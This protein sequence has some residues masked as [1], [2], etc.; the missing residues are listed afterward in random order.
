MVGRFE[1]LRLVPEVMKQVNSRSPTQPTG[2][3]AEKT[4]VFHGNA[5]GV[6]V[7]TRRAKLDS[8]APRVFLVSPA[9][10]AGIRAQ[11]LFPPETTSIL[12]QRLIK[13]GVA[14]EELFCF[15]SSLYFRGKLAYARLFANPPRSLPGVLIIAAGLGLQPPETV[16]TASDVQQMSSVQ[17]DLAHPEYR[18]ALERDARTLR[19]NIG[20]DVPVVL[21]GSIATQKYVE[22]LA[23]IFGE[24]LLFPSAFVGRGSMSRGGLLLRCC[25]EKVEL[26]YVP[27]ITTLRRGARP[28]RLLPRRP[29]VNKG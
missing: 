24:Q 27:V 16:V 1:F 11:R 13:N 18:S 22:P 17:V 23:E 29:T 5:P 25:R 21:L 8:G 10:L 3:R 26:D 7:T 9:N 2:V 14:L 6:G 20:S 19:E 28:P 12:G 15:I 4:V